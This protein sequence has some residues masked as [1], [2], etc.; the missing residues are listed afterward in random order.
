MEIKRKP[1]PLT[2]IKQKHVRI[3]R[4]FYIRDRYWKIITPERHLEHEVR[5][6]SLAI[7][8]DDWRWQS[9]LVVLVTRPASN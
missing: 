7:T 6:I 9:L 1:C 5:Y 2:Y 4:P 3:T 8:Y